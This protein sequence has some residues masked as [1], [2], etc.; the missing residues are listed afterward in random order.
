[1]T[2]PDGASVRSHDRSAEAWW[3]DFSP[4]CHRLWW[5]ALAL[6][7]VNDNL[8]KGG[9]LV[10]GWLTGKLSDFAFLVVAPVLL[11]TLVPLRVRG[12]RSLAFAVV[13]SVYAAADLSPA[14]SD[15]IVA[16]AARLGLRWRLWPDLTDLM[17]LTVLPVSWRIAGARGRRPL[18]SA[19][20][21]VQA[22][23]LA[24]GV[25]A[26]LATGDDPGYQHYPFFVNRTS[27]PRTVSM[28][29]VL[30]KT[31]CGVDVTALAASLQPGDLDDPH[32]VTVVK[33]QVAA[34]DG[35]PSAAA[36]AGVCQ[37]RNHT[38][39]NDTDCMAVIVAVEGG[40][41]VLVS[42]PRIWH[43]GSNALTAIDAC[44]KDSAS[45]SRCAAT[46][47]A[48]EDPGPDALSLRESAGQLKFQAGAK[49]RIAPIDIT[50]V[51]GRVPSGSGCRDLRKEIHA[52]LDG[53]TSCSIDSD[54]Q[55]LKV[56]IAIPGGGICVADVNQS[57]ASDRLTQL[58]Q[59]WI[60]GCEVDSTLVCYGSGHSPICN[61]GTCGELCAGISV[62]TCLPSCTSVGQVPHQAC[63]P[64]TTRD[65]LSADE[66]NCSC[67][68]TGPAFDQYILTCKPQPD[69]P[70]CPVRCMPRR[71]SSDGG[72]A[73]GA[74]GGRAE[75]RGAEV[76]AGQD[77]GQILGRD[78]GYDVS[79]D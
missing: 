63:S 55:A 70:G 1:M 21:V 76:D 57:V 44:W 51:A 30:R 73:D 6:L 16:A 64:A 37:N 8:L 66:Q 18:R 22:T 58:R 52:I 36:V 23:G 15:A 38:R 47:S 59:A 45:P 68:G 42:A 7:L 26:C 29:W 49:L 56:D 67:T 33:G 78:L 9:G 31:E 75:A 4:L 72:A 41:A 19:R 79:S 71:D 34:L 43:E 65:C 74:S 60:A 48:G 24:I 5:A 20:T 50:E 69:I 54:C 46:L 27:A 3:F 53:A 61:A 39:S 35:P 13:V 12:R 11:T 77:L 2:A 10:P 40:P 32:P 28:T 17:A 25:F 62:P 14:A